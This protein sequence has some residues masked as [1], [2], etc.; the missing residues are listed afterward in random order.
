[1][2]G[3]ILLGGG[4]Y[5]GG[6]LTHLRDLRHNE[7]EL[8]A[9]EWASSYTLIHNVMTT[10][11]F[12]AAEM[13]RRNAALA[14]DDIIRGTGFD[15][16][17]VNSDERSEEIAVQACRLVG[18]DE[19]RPDTIIVCQSQSDSRAHENS[20][21]A[22]R[23]QNEF[24]VKDFVFGL[25]DQEAAAGVRAIDLAAHLVADG[26]ARDVLLCGVQKIVQPCPRILTQY[27]V[28]GDGA[29][30]CRLSAAEEL[31]WCIDFIET[32]TLDFL[33]NPWS[34]FETDIDLNRIADSLV[35]FVEEQLRHWGLMVKDFDLVLRSG[36]NGRIDRTLVER[37]GIAA[38]SSAFPSC[39]GGFLGSAEVP[40]MM[41]KLSA[42]DPPARQGQ[43]CLMIALG[44]GGRM[45]LVTLSYR[46]NK[47]QSEFQPVEVPIY[48]HGTGYYVPDPP[49]SV[50]DWGQ[51]NAVAPET[52]AEADKNGVR[53]FRD[54]RDA[55]VYDLISRAVSNVLD[56]SKVNPAKIDLVLVAH[57]AS[58]PVIPGPGDIV[59]KLQSEFGMQVI[60]GFSIGQQ[61]CVSIISAIRI[62]SLL[63]RR[64]SAINTVLV[65]SGDQVRSE[66]DIFRLLGTTAIQS[67]GGS[68]LILSRV[69]SEVRLEA[70]YNYSDT[71][72]WLGQ[73]DNVETNRSFV[74]YNIRLILRL[75]KNSGVAPE[76]LSSCLTPNINRDIWPL[77]LQSSK[78]NPELIDDSL[79][80]HVGH[81][82]GNDWIISLTESKARGPI[83]CLSYGLCD[84]FGG[85]V[86]NRA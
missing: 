12:D 66:V 60:D 68:A 4:H 85:V 36:L 7:E 22:L 53:I 23:L 5:L 41:S 1:M 33:D 74:F 15:R 82:F 50:V 52:V 80:N 8:V 6:K 54:S 46:W 47:S 61:N 37:L 56:S 34:T 24:K 86:V 27:T 13:R 25:M 35:C 44:F 75:L 2:S 14:V 42:C 79:F 38:T 49:I 17:S 72:N 83:L 69:P 30:A 9:P 45:G 32:K 81:V 57:T 59:R 64:N 71:A 19:Q 43:R 28:L 55:P 11:G 40:M 16:V 26:Q 29:A 67:D 39:L 84:C 62:A 18:F 10:N 77:I 20:S 76:M 63:L 48:I 51:R 21:V 31:G 70:A 3:L 73:L 58:A 78:L 65:A